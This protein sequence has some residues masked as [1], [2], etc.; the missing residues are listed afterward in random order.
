[1]AIQ[2]R[3]IQAGTMILGDLTGQGN[4]K[5]LASIVESLRMALD[6][7]AIRAMV[8]IANKAQL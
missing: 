1:M 5:G 4:I 2:N 6:S 8:P 7:G 3:C